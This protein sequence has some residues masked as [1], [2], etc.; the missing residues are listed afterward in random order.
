M[1]R[2]A[3]LVG[4]IY[5]AGT[6]FSSVPRNALLSSRSSKNPSPGFFTRESEAVKR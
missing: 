4:D 5:G 2:K 3:F 1:A 6:M